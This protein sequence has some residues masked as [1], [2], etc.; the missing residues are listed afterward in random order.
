MHAERTLSL[1]GLV[2]LYQD[3]ERR[4][5]R[6]VPNATIAKGTVMSQQNGVFFPYSGSQPKCILEYDCKTDA[7]GRAWYYIAI[8]MDVRPLDKASAFFKGTFNCQD[9]TGLDQNAAIALGRLLEGDYL[10]GI[11]RVC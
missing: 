4:G 6:L 2:P 9:L 5:I 11:L 7:A 8:G 10:N 1:A 3:F